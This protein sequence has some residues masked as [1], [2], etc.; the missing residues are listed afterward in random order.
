LVNF[1]VRGRSKEK[2]EVEIERLRHMVESFL[3][4]LAESNVPPKQIP[5]ILGSAP[6]PLEKIAGN[7]RHHLVLRGSEPSRV[8]QIAT[9][10]YEQYKAPSGMYLEID[11]DP[12]QML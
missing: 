5:D 7:W 8:L 6:C 1:T 3:R 12:L 2:T 4:G 11:L 9:G 10:V